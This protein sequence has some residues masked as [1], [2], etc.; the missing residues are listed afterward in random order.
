[1]QKHQGKSVVYIGCI[2][3]LAVGYAVFGTLGCSNAC[4]ECGP[5]PGSGGAG[6]VGGAA[7]SGGSAGVA[8]AAGTGGS[9]S[10]DPDAAG[11]ICGGIAGLECPE[12][13][14]MFC[15]YPPTAGTD[16]TGICK[17]RPTQCMK[18]CPGVCGRDG[19]FYCNACEAN[20]A[21]TDDSPPGAC[22]DASSPK[23]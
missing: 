12:P 3:G 2:L 16:G 21:G 15:D 8:G 19:K 22:A 18:D 11:V 23:P 13:M 14:T 20:R 7:G 6:A 9:G 5:G 17:A 1:M 10:N 4:A